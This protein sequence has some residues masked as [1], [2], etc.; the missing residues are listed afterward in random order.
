MI[1]LYVQ[2]DVNFLCVW[3]VID[4][5]FLHNIVK[6]AMDLQDDSREDLRTT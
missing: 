1:I 6:V 3:P 5:E 2:I 4:H